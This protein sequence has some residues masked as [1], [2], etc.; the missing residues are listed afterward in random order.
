M[1]EGAVENEEV[2]LLWDITIRCDNVL[3]ARKPDIVV[4]DKKKRKG[5][6]FILLY[7]LT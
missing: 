3:E 7:Q 4:V 1:P 5:M 2:K 6:I